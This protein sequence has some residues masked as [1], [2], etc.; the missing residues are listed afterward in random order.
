[1]NARSIL[2]GE[3]SA[4]NPRRRLSPEIAARAK[5]E[6]AGSPVHRSPCRWYPC[7]SAQSS[8]TAQPVRCGMNPRP[9]RLLD[10]VG[11][12]IRRNHYSPSTGESYANW[13]KHSILVH[14]KRHPNEMSARRWRPS[15]GI[16]RAVA[17]FSASG[18]RSSCPVSTRWDQT[19][20]ESSPPGARSWRTTS[21]SARCRRRCEK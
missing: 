13:I 6:C 12:A 2:P 5:A 16:C 15:R 19:P 17:A 18:S 14:G 8:A 7:T 4:Y 21:L 10:Q 3:C 20:R 9:K 1:M 11:E